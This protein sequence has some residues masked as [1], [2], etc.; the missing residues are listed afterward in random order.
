MIFAS[1]LTSSFFI[2][3]LLQIIFENR[4]RN[5]RGRT[6]KI[7]VDGADCAI[8]EPWLWELSFNR[9]LFSKK[10]NGAGAKYK[11]GV[12]IQTGD[13]VWVNGPFKTGKWHTITVYRNN[14]KGL[15]HPGKMVETYR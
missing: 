4:F 15:L 5:D 11:V 6:C 8:S 12:C 14:L 13:I 7:T 9:Q 1:Y 3:S 2:S 10:L